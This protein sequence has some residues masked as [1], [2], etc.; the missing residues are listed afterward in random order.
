MQVIYEKAG[1]IS[2]SEYEKVFN[3]PKT[4]ICV[5]AKLTR[6][7]K[8]RKEIDRFYNFKDTSDYPLSSAHNDHLSLSY[9]ENGIYYGKHDGTL[10]YNNSA[11]GGYGLRVSTQ[12]IYNPKFASIKNC[13]EIED[14]VDIYDCGDPIW[15]KGGINRKISGK[16]YIVTFGGIDYV[17][18]NKEECES[19]QALVMQLWNDKLDIAAYPFDMYEY[20]RNRT[21]PSA[22]SLRKQCFEYVTENCTPEELA[23][24]VTVR[25]TRRDGYESKTLVLTPEIQL[26]VIEAFDDYKVSKKT[27]EDAKR[28]TNALLEANMLE[29]MRDFTTEEEVEA[30]ANALKEV[31]EYKQAELANIIIEENKR[32]QDKTMGF[33]TVSRTINGYDYST[34]K[35]ILK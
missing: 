32:K 26:K 7:A 6:N 24:L 28:L 20:G 1:L 13:R 23:M 22:V 16:K 27:E 10:D 2:K 34:G 19:G 18:L 35:E 11:Y 17:W 21:Y 31:I 5:S 12:I 14:E 33:K 25:R 8:V 29:S 3:N 15:N 30:T 9:G 4:R